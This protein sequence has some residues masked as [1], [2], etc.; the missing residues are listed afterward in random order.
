MS[1][2]E[3]PFPDERATLAA[4]YA[5]GVLAADE[6]REAERRIGRDS[7]FAADVQAWQEMLVPLTERLELI[8]P[9]ASVWQRVQAFIQSADVASFAD[10]ELLGRI[11]RKMAF[12]RGLAFGSLGLAAASLAGLLVSIPGNGPS[13]PVVQRLASQGGPSGILA[14]FDPRGQTLLVVPAAPSAAEQR[15]P[16]LWLL[17]SGGAPRSLGV[18]V[19]GRPATVSLPTDLGAQAGRQ[20]IVAISLEPPG[21]SPTGA[22]TGP[23]IAR[24]TLRRL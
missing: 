11:R 4:E 5:L 6:R 21:G 3:N 16:E 8:D 14:T 9:P 23:V 7:Q 1:G 20:P 22:P 2:N 10:P 12:W 13:I 17:P 19:P 15:V 18:I 24:G